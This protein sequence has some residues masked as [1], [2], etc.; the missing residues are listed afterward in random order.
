MQNNMCL[1]ISWA[2]VA[3]MLAS[4]SN[5]VVDVKPQ[6]SQ[7][8]S[9]NHDLNISKVDTTNITNTHLISKNKRAEN[10]LHLFDMS[11]QPHLQRYLQEV[12]DN[13]QQLKTIKRS[14][15]A[16][17]MTPKMISAQRKPS[18]DIGLSGSRRKGSQLAGFSNTF[19]LN[20]NA[21]WSLD[22]WQKIKDEQRSAELLVEQE[23]L[24]LVQA[25]RLVVAQALHLWNLHS[26]QTQQHKLLRK[27]LK[28]TNA[29]LASAKQCYQLG[30][31]DFNDYLLHRKKRHDLTQALKLNALEKSLLVQ[32]LNALRGKL[33]HE[34]VEIGKQRRL[35]LS[36]LPQTLNAKVI[37]TRPDIQRAFKGIQALDLQT[38]AA[39]KALLPS[40][41]ISTS[42]LRDASK[43]NQLFDGSLMWQLVGSVSQPLINGD[44]LRNQAKQKSLEAEV[45]LLSYQDLVMQA[46]HGVEKK[47]AT[48]N[49]LLQSLRD[50]KNAYQDNVILIDSYQA[51]YLKGNADLTEFLQAKD[52]FLT[53]QHEV[54]KTEFQ[55]AENRLQLALEL[56]M[57]LYVLGVLL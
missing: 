44:V 12:L 11:K 47:I 51:R 21:K 36:P 43:L 45:A 32:Q 14:V 9:Y 42:L 18:V 16:M 22:I 27:Q 29:L 54:V 31:C 3:M 24:N 6:A 28:N 26:L 5:K 53:T 50:Q 33:P 7:V 25:R 15:K 34:H 46:I 40:I 49:T 13:N 4:C 20:L 10:H 56:G 1:Y 37:E 41:D 19:D 48:E 57:P 2:M 23:K 55:I 38:R 52:E 35:S 17:S 30:L 39:Y 8:T